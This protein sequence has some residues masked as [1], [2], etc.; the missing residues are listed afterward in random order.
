VIVNE[1]RDGSVMP[2]PP[3]TP[4]DL[5]LSLIR[6]VDALC[7]E[8]AMALQAGQ[9]PAIR[10]FLARIGPTAQSQLLDE[11]IG[12]ELDHWEKHGFDDPVSKVLQLHPELGERIGDASAVARTATHQAEPKDAAASEQAIRGGLHVRC[13]H[14]H[15]PIEFV[16]DIELESIACPSCGSD[17]SLVGEGS[18]MPNTQAVLGVRQFKFLERV[19]VGAFGAVW[20]AHDT[21]LDRTVAVKIP[22]RGQFDDEQAKAFLREAQNAAQL[23]HPGIVPVYEVGR[24]GDTLYIVSEF[25]RGITLADWLSGQRPT[26]REAAELGVQIATA[27]HHAHER[28]V[29]HR[30]LKPGNVMLDEHLATHLMDFGLAKREAS[31]VT[32]TFDG[33]LLGTPAYMSPEQ[34]DGRGHWADR[35]SDVYSLGVLLFELLTGEM[36]FRGDARTQVHQRLVEDPPDPRTLNRLVPRDLSTICLKCLER[37][38]NRRYPTAGHVGR[39]LQR[40]LR[41]EPIQARPISH[42]GRL[43]RWCR[44][45]KVAALAILLTLVLALGGPIVAWRIEMQR[46]RLADLV[47]EKTDL[48]QRISSEKQASVGELARL[49][50]ELAKWTGRA[51]PWQLWPPQKEEGPRLKMLMRAYEQHYHPMVRR[52]LESRTFTTQQRLSGQLGLAIMADTIGNNEQAL[53]HYEQAQSLLV[54]L[55]QETPDDRVLTRMLAESHMHLSRLQSGSQRELASNSL[56][57]A[58]TLF[59]KLSKLDGDQRSRISKVDAYLRRAVFAGFEDASRELGEAAVLHDAVNRDWPSNPIEF[60]R[61]VCLLAQQEPTLVLR[62]SEKEPLA[63]DE[64]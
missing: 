58:I 30:D 14:C 28:G 43:T 57:Q 6:R 17:F 53:R 44:R 4:D 52:L 41:G 48:I 38:P 10:D 7:D 47:K 54:Q 16:S 25:V 1:D 39:E 61:L 12:V 60:Y 33:Q 62:G 42:L 21:K 63:P 20:K 5:P 35:R 19:G 13:P 56:D 55:L 18:A 49:H 32:M 40:H 11:L 9:V 31:E 8:Y 26:W 22:R 46:Q 24:D 64:R 37:D 51:N 15:H 27:L 3:I 29:I 50:G 2:L 59:D 23:N 45:K 36:P 34:A